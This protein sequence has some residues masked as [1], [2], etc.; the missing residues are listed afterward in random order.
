MTNA[1]NPKDDVNVEKLYGK[2]CTLSKEDF[3]KTYNISEKGLSSSEAENRIHKYGLNEISQAKP[4][5]SYNY[6]LESLF[7]PFNSIL[8]R[9]CF[10]TFLY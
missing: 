6:F 9:N 2:E 7:S 1:K 10:N 4:K 5:K 8:L 3:I